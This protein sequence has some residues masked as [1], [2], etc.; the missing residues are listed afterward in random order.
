MM[1]IIVNLI[2]C[3]LFI[4]HWYFFNSQDLWLYSWYFS[5]YNQYNTNS[6]EL[7][8][9]EFGKCI[10]WENDPEFQKFEQQS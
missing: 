7:A 5:L 6:K 9:R 3:I 4:I 8:W 1:I 2:V 10:A